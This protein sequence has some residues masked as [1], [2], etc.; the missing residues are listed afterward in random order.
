MYLAI[1]HQTVQGTTTTTVLTG[2]G[3]TACHVVDGY[4]PREGADD[5]TPVVD[6]FDLILN[7]TEAANKALLRVIRMALNSAE[8]FKD[9]QR[10]AYLY[11]DP[12]ASV[13]TAAYR[14]RIVGGRVMHSEKLGREITNTQMGLTIIIERDPWWEAITAVNV[15]LTNGNGTDLITNLRVYNCGDNATVDTSYKRDN[16]V[17]IDGVNDVAGD[18]PAIANITYYNDADLD[19]HIRTIH[20]FNNVN[21]YPASF[22]S[23]IEA[24]EYGADTVLTGASAGNVGSFTIPTAADTMFWYLDIDNQV[25]Y[26]STGY[27]VA[28]MRFKYDQITNLANLKFKVELYEATQG[29]L[30][31]SD[32]FYPTSAAGEP[33][34]ALSPIFRLQPQE[35]DSY[36]PSGYLLRIYAYQETGGDVTLI[37]DDIHILPAENYRMIGNDGIN[38][39]VGFDDFDFLYDLQV[40][41]LCYEHKYFNNDTFSVP[42]HIG[43]L[44]I[45]PGVNQKITWIYGMTTADTQTKI[46]SAYLWVKI[47][48]RPRRQTI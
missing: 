6:K 18:M 20:A 28:V 22:D 3:T 5:V 40:N 48:C 30:F 2:T 10:R 25:K 15:P 39:R 47:S 35:E 16:W 14:S 46:N 43:K 31:K 19:I 36:T 4:F 12:Y 24:E 27:F 32:Y 29:T 42:N 17:T 44:M 21:S 26:A 9:T 33:V 45:Y 1:N 13:V 38:L 37:M 8:K 23:L 34:Y 41:D 7:G 11:Y